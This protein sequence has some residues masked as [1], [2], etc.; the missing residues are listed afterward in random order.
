MDNAPNGKEKGREMLGEVGP[1]SWGVGARGVGEGRL[2]PSGWLL[3]RTWG[4]PVSVRPRR[5]AHPQKS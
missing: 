4:P 2:P 1:A 5:P 3:P